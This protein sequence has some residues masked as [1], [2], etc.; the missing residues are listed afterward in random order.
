M[1]DVD[2]IVTVLSIDAFPYTGKAVLLL[3]Y[4]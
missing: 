3:F 2:K 1:Y 4:M